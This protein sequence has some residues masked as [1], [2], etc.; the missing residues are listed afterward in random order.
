MSPERLKV[1]IGDV[2]RADY[3]GRL[4]LFQP[5]SP[6]RP[7]PERH[8]VPVRHRPA[9]PHKNP[10][11]DAISHDQSQQLLDLATKER[12]LQDLRERKKE[13]EVQIMHAESDVASAKKL[14]AMSNNPSRI[15]TNNS[16]A[17]NINPRNILQKEKEMETLQHLAEGVS[18]IWKDVVQAT[19][20]EHATT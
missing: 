1:C 15:L 4:I 8:N 9:S 20:G 3:K 5:D 19:I 16:N 6:R 18:A 13:L 17:K 12:A 11:L 14:L 7:S 2:N 10:G